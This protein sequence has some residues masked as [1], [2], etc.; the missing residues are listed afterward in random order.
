MKVNTLKQ[1]KDTLATLKKTRLAICEKVSSSQAQLRNLE[2]EYQRILSQ[3]E[4]M[5]EIIHKCEKL[6]LEP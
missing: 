6:P 1:L 3:E 2:E 5:K 4:A